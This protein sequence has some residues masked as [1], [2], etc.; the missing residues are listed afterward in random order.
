MS[1]SLLWLPEIIYKRP[2]RKP[3]HLGVTRMRKI[4]L[5]ADLS[6]SRS[7]MNNYS[8]TGN[9]TTTS[10][11]TIGNHLLTSIPREIS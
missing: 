1:F 2:P 7:S 4:T 5:F 8:E 10:A 9:Y 11:H 3:V 6:I